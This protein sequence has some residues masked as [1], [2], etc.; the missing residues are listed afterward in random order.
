MHALNLLLRSQ[1]VYFDYIF[2]HHYLYL[3]YPGLHHAVSLG[4]IDAPSQVKMQ[5]IF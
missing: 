3:L 1:K 2:L 4:N 5:L